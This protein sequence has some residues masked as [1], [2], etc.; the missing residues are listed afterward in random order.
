[1]SGNNGS[2]GPQHDSHPQLVI[3]QNAV[4]TSFTGT[5]AIGS[6]GVT[7]ASSTKL[8]AG[9][10]VSGIGIPAGTTILTVNSSTSITL[11]ASAT[12]TGLEGLT[13]NGWPGH[14]CLG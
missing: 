4:P 13:A 5:L 2:D 11:S 1:M 10:E 7:V 8:F 9:E 14:D 12:V 3:N 6:V